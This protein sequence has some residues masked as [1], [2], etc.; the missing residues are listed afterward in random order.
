MLV[1]CVDPD[2]F[3][4]EEWMLSIVVDALVWDLSVFLTPSIPAAI[5]P[6]SAIPDVLSFS[7][8]LLQIAFRVA[9]G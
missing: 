8:G 9:E 4:A 6:L 2:N 3:G 1:P 5:H 7:S